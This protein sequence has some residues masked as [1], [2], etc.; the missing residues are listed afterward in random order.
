M[1]PRHFHFFFSFFHSSTSPLLLHYISLRTRIDITK[2][3]NSPLSVKIKLRLTL[4]KFQM[5][6]RLK[7][8]WRRSRIEEAAKRRV[9]MPILRSYVSH[10][11]F[12]SL[13][14]DLCAC[15]SF[16]CPSP[17][18]LHLFLPSLSQPKRT[19]QSSLKRSRPLSASSQ[20]DSLL[21]GESP[22]KRTKVD[23]VRNR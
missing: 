13:C 6:W 16:S 3:K 15:S 22:P 18:S 1:L 4:W 19:P 7:R 14:A 20:S 21:D 23:L 9:R 5:Q 2:N 12:S 17:T 10:V 11:P 8:K